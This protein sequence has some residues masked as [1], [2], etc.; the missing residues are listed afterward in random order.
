VVPRFGL[1]AVANK[2]EIFS[3][4][5]S[6]TELR[7]FSP[8]PSHYTDSYRNEQTIHNKIEKKNSDSAT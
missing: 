3:L 2:K 5:L 4:S 6:E 8:R 1:D 7:S